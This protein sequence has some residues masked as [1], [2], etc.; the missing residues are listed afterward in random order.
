MTLFIFGELC[1]YDYFSALVPVVCWESFLS[2]IVYY[3]MS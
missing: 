2:E 1:G 3:R